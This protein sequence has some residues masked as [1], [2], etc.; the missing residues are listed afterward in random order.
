MSKST[1]RVVFVGNIPYGL[2]EEQI[3][4]I[5]S[6]AGKVLN[7]RLVY[8][9][10]T[11]RPKGFGFAE[12]PD[13]D[14]AASAVRNLNDYETMGRKL[15]V[16][17]SNEGGGDNDNDGHPHSH[18]R[19]GGS[20]G[21]GQS[22]PAP[23]QGSSLPPLPPGK[24]LPPNVTAT[25]AISRTLNTLPPSQL[26]DILGQMK[27]LAVS[28]PGRATELLQQAPQLSYAIFQALL[29]MGLVSPESIHS[30][31]DSSAPVPQ[32][33]TA[34]YPP[35]QG[36]IYPPVPGGANNTPPVAATPYAAPPQA[37]PYG[38]IPPAPAP[39]PDTE[40]L[41]RQVME[42]PMETINLLPE[43]ERAQVLALRAQFGG[44]RR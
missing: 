43:A 18:T 20:N 42:L 22:A 6:S 39:P 35:Q 9:R 14:S 4:D 5:F 26:L 16:D 13:H 17:F 40:A 38:A 3:T 44:Q 28:D 33:V 37:A 36:A 24:D 32:P 12:Y 8:D 23:S 11:G 19:D 31:L 25:D 1:S 7:F 2:S 10:E 29:L 34:G 27:A 41:V 21:Y 15:R 30:V